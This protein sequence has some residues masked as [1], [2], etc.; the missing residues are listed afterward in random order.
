MDSLC[1]SGKLITCGGGWCPWAVNFG[2]SDRYTRG[3]NVGAPVVGTGDVEK[4]HDGV[5]KVRTKSIDD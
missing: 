4:R 2:L 3:K 5:W 1:Q